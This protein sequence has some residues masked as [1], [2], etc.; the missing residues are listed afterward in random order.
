MEWIPTH[1]MVQQVTPHQAKFMTR[2]IWLSTPLVN[3]PSKLWL[4][5]SHFRMNHNLVNQGST[6]VVEPR[7]VYQGWYRYKT[8]D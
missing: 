3:H 7:V 8:G 6:V 4:G 2:F 5:L 1:N